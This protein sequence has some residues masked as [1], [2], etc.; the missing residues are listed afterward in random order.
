[1]LVGPISF[2]PN[3]LIS[4]IVEILWQC[5]PE[6]RHWLKRL[7]LADRAF[8]CHCQ[9]HLCEELTFMPYLNSLGEPR[10]G[11]MAPLYPTLEE[12][13]TV[14]EQSPHLAAYVRGITVKGWDPVDDLFRRP[15]FMDIIRRVAESSSSSKSPPPLARLKFISTRFGNPY[16]AL[17]VIVRPFLYRMGITR[18]DLQPMQKRTGHIVLGS[19]LSFA[20]R[21]R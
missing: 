12:R 14:V 16:F 21:S 4:K 1:M 7:A 5:G 13:C 19:P 6:A 10:L 15:A 3:E 20:G 11:A 8:A 2:L 17:N 9:P 18:L